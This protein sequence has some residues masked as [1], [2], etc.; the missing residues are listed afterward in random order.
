MKATW[1]ILLLPVIG[2]LHAF[3]FFWTYGRFREFE[4]LFVLFGL[5]ALSL[6]ISALYCSELFKSN[7]LR[8]LNATL[9]G[10]LLSMVS[11]FVGALLAFNTYG[12]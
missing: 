8:G 4:G 11:A 9:V 7:R 3:G 2:A 1:L 5:V 10:L 12:T 6:Y